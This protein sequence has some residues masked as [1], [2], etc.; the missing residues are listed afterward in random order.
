MSKCAQRMINVSG[1]SGE[2]DKEASSGFW[3]NYAKRSNRKKEKFVPANFGVISGE[4]TRDK[5]LLSCEAWAGRG[6]L[7]FSSW[8]CNFSGENDRFPQT[9]LGHR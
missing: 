4:S 7:D 8:H 2:T 5:C 9:H 1:T 6:S 3:A